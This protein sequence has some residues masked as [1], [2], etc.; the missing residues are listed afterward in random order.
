MDL[1]DYVKWWM[2][3][4]FGKTPRPLQ[5][6]PCI[7]LLKMAKRIDG[8]YPSTFVFIAPTSGGKSLTRDTVGRILR[9]A[10]WTI[11]PLLSL[12]AD[13]VE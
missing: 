13:Q 3:E 1:E 7:A 9:G 5:L 11:C 8:A 6:P 10:Y 4:S 2:K 12:S